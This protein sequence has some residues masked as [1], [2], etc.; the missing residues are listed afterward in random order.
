M[1][2][3]MMVIRT[4]GCTFRACH[5]AV[6]YYVVDSAFKSCFQIYFSLCCWVARS[7][8][9]QDEHDLSLLERFSTCY[10]WKR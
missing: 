8:I 7:G 5:F 6:N 2:C 9:F 1:E 10:V 4:S 3:G